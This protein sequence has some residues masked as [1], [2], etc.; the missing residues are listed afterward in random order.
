MPLRFELMLAFG[1][2]VFCVGGLARTYMNIR[3][4]QSILAD[5]SWW[6]RAFQSTEVTYRR[7]VR[8]QH[9]RNV[10]KLSINARNAPLWPLVVAIV[11]LPLGMVICFAAMVL[12]TWR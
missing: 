12:T 10:W 9:D 7:L 5:D 8:E 6:R 1:F 11:C 2:L 4:S 3:I